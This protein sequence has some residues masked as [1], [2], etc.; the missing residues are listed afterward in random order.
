MSEMDRV[1][2]R[3]EALTPEYEALWER[4]CSFETPSDNK[5]ALDEQSRYLA[6]YAKASGFRVTEYPFP[7]AGNC[8]TADTKGN[9][10]SP[11]RERGTSFCSFHIVLR[12][13]NLYF[14]DFLCKNGAYVEKYTYL[15]V[16]FGELACQ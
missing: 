6:A 13:N 14:Q 5:E 11:S 4:I 3:I 2:A 15:C 7:R 8:L 16:N 12:P 10:T 1:F 9:M